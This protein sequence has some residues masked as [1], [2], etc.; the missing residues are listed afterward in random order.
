MTAPVK[1][2]IVALSFILLSSFC[3][4]LQA[5]E[6]DS[7]LSGFEE[8][9]S[10]DDEDDLEE[11]LGGFSELETE[12][13]DVQPES[14]PLLPDWLTF[15]GSVSLQS[16]INVAQSEP[17]PGQPDYRGLSMFRGHGELIAEASFSEWKARIGGTAF[18]DAAYH[19]NDQRDLYTDEYLDEYEDELELNEAYLQGSLSSALDIKL[20]RQIVVWGK[21]D[22][23]RVTDILNPLD[24]RYP[25]MLDIRYLR[26]PVTMSRIDYF[27]D[28]WNIN[29]MLIHE[30]RFD[31]FTRYNGEFFPGI[32]PLPPLVTPD[33]SWENQQAGLALN[34]I[35]SGWDL[36]FY[37]ASVFQERA[38]LSNDPEGKPFRT[39]DNRAV[40]VGSAADIVLG[41][42]LFKGEAAYWDG[43]KYS[44]VSDEKPRFDILAGLEYMGFPETTVSFEI[45]N[46]HIIDY[47]PVMESLPDGQ[48]ED[49]TQ[50]ALRFVKDFMNDT[51]HLTCLIS[52]YGLLGADGGFER[53]QLDYDLTDNVSVMAGVV[54]YESGNFP[55]FKE[56]GSNDRLLFELEYRF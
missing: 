26:L 47:D 22:N 56:I 6:L 36:S 42:W 30:P 55:G 39:H 53:F 52:S 21:S 38:Y 48:K 32:Q 45:V 24:R 25:G 3:V 16:T 1:N 31:K 20:G 19:L 7:L 13:Q 15:Q 27:W 10:A 35:F 28:R 33:W 50:Y 2:S 17:M 46:R 9:S 23:L 41:S 44:T 29:A 12:P 18:Y 34:G 8:E 37:A 51:L 14:D 49:W 43:L 4:Q 11:L 5:D 40:M 54:F